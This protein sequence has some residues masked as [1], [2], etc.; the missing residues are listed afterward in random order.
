[1]SGWEWVGLEGKEGKRGPRQRGN[2]WRNT[3]GGGWCED[4]S[5]WSNKSYLYAQGELDQ[6]WGPCAQLPWLGGQAAGPA[7]WLWQ[8]NL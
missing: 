4:S 3:G 6:G 2:R 7:T 8:G 5:L 1:M